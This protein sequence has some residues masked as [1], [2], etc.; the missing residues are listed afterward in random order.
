MMASN[1]GYNW[2]NKNSTVI[3]LVTDI[4]LP[5]KHDINTNIFT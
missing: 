4:K 2:P 5:K 3:A 1:E